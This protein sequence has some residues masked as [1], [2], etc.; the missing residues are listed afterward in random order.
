[1]C[2]ACRDRL[3]VKIAINMKE[4]MFRSRKQAIAVAYS[5][6]KRENAKCKGCFR[7]R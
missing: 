5:Q 4:P 1:M 7:R 2:D 3:S 6:V